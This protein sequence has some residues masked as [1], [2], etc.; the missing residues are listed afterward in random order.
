MEA[1]ILNKSCLKLLRDRDMST[2]PPKIFNFGHAFGDVRD[3]AMKFC[4]HKEGRSSFNR[5]LISQGF[6]PTVAKLL[7]EDP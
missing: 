5:F 2:F 7:S 4:A 3:A 6:V 1:E